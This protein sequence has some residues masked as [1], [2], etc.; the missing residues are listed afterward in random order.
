MLNGFRPPLSSAKDV[1]LNM[2][3]R[4]LCMDALLA[5]PR[6]GMWPSAGVS[7]RKKLIVQHDV[8]SIVLAKQVADSAQVGHVHV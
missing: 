6:T 7:N 4:A 8:P 5:Q 1:I 2:H 3:G